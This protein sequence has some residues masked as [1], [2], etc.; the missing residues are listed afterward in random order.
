M[1]WR[2]KW[3]QFWNAASIL[4]ILLI[5]NEANKLSYVLGRLN[6]KSKHHIGYYNF[7][8]HFMGLY[9]YLSGFLTYQLPFILE[10]LVTSYSPTD[11]SFSLVVIV[12]DHQTYS[13]A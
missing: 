5:G 10:L 6:G 1:N 11:R 4:D 12:A 9:E 7:T 3:P 13:K 8:K 2:G